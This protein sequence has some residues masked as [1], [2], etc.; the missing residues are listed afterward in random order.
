MSS[1]IRCKFCSGSA[2]KRYLA[3]HY[4]LNHSSHPLL[5]T[6]IEGPLESP[7][8][9]GA[10]R[11]SKKQKLVEEKRK[12]KAAVALVPALTKKSANKEPTTYIL[13]KNS[14]KR[15]ARPKKIIG[16]GSQSLRPSKSLS[17]PLCGERLSRGKMLEH[18]AQAHGER[19]IPPAA[20]A[21]RRRKHVWV[22]VVQG[23][24]PGLGK[25][26]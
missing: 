14:I 21:P 17:C 12:R 5:A 1:F 9:I 11:P 8:L 22:Q 6:V 3:W 19:S 18:K 16:T 25:R 23:G 2:Q 26:R 24:L 20:S 7:T 15:A 10:K 4:S 13:P